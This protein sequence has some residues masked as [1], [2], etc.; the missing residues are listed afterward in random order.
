[1]LA[2]SYTCIAKRGDFNR[3]RA[4]RMREK[5]LLV[6][7]YGAQVCV[8]KEP[9][10]PFL[11]DL[12]VLFCMFH[13]IVPKSNPIRTK[14]VQQTLRKLS[15]DSASRK[16]NW[17]PH[18]SDVPF[19]YSQPT[20][21]IYRDVESLSSFA[22][23]YSEFRRKLDYN[24][25]AN[26]IESRQ[27][28]QDSILEPIATSPQT[29]NSPWA[30]FSAGS[31]A[32]GK[33]YVLARLQENHLLDLNDFMKIDPDKIK[34]ELP[35]LAGYLQVQKDTA[36]TKLHREST[37]MADILLEMGIAKRYPLL[38]DGSLRDV[39]YYTSLF[40]RLKESGYRIAILHIVANREVILE[41]ARRRGEAT[42]RFV[43]LEILEASMRQVPASVQSLSQ[44]ATRTFTIQNNEGQPMELLS[45]KK[46]DPPPTW[47]DFRNA[48]KEEEEHGK[49]STS[50]DDS[51]GGESSHNDEIRPF[52]V[53]MCDAFEDTAM[54]QTANKMF[55]SSYPNFC[56]RCAVACDGQCGICIHGKHLCSCNECR[57]QQGPENFKSSD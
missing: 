25:H 35:E 53:N 51:G 23:K 14:M 20:N 22:N 34:S 32:V 29:N 4:K 5:I 56:A 38:V 1:M 52:Y 19:D 46:D 3:A 50:R 7:E 10:T 48:W 36:A 6:T 27:H 26:P 13:T 21:E 2:V 43:P 41:R 28:L 11:E 30:I 57:A 16:T 49:E 44:F 17:P 18:N 54:H 15:V 37:Q 45:T 40:A 39:D 8:S 9:Y 55:Q 33:G 31:M 47:Q 42:G 24:Y 12:S